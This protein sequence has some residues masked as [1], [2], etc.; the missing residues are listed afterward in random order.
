MKHTRRAS[1]NRYRGELNRHNILQFLKLNDR[2]YSTIEL[3]QILNINRVSVR[4]H[5]VNLTNTGAISETALL[6]HGT[7]D[8]R[9]RKVFHYRFNSA[10]VDTTNQVR[11]KEASRHL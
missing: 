3:S 1:D 6:K 7:N 2:W 4:S 8:N 5:C 10:S 9:R 11:I